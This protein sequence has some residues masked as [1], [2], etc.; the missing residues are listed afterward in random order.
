MLRIDYTQQYDKPLVLALGFFDCMHLGHMQLVECAKKLAGDNA[1]VGI[2]TFCNNHFAQLGKDA[3]LLYSYQERL[4]IYSNCG[5]NVVV[6]AV[7]DR[8]FMALTG[9]M[10][11][12]ALVGN[13]NIVGIV[14]G[15]DHRSGSDMR[16]HTHIQQYCHNHNIP[17]TVVSQISNN[18]GVKISSSLVRQLVA[19][20]DFATINTLLSQPYHISGTV[21]SGRGVGHRL[22]FATAN[23][24]VSA[25]KLLPTGVFVGNVELSDSSTYR[26]IINIGKAPTFS[27]DSVNVEAHLLGYNGDLYGQFVKVYITRYLREIVCFDTKEQLIQQL[28]H[29]CTEA[30]ND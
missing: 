15:Y 21:N 27:V 14:C 10:Y 1:D 18:D 22:G 11:L 12:N 17:C 9:D 13:K 3:K 26:A 5:I 24:S 19:D 20:N 23:V 4:D 6:E 25:D 7:F 30:V 28:Q 16:D 8:Q 29:D 2:M